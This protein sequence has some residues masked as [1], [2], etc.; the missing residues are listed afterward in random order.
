MREDAGLIMCKQSHAAVRAAALMF[1][2]RRRTTEAHLGAQKAVFVHDRT[3]LRIMAAL[4]VCDGFA[5]LPTL[6]QP[7]AHPSPS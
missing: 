6:Q 2:P 1:E 5:Q 7:P 4:Q 3:D